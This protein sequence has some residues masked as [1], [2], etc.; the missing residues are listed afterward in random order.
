[1]NKMKIEMEYD[2]ELDHFYVRGSL[3]M[4]RAQFHV[5]GYKAS[6]V[7]HLFEQE[8]MHEVEAHKREQRKVK[9]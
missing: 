6:Q 7:L 9:V 8:L 5:T 4:H 2:P 3:P 1:M